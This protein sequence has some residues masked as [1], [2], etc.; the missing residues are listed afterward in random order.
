LG[1]EDLPVREARRIVGPDAMIG[2]STHTIEQARLAA[3]EG[4]DYIG[5]GPVFLSRTKQF[6]ELAGLALVEQIACEIGLPAFCIGGIE[7]ANVAQVAH[8][9][10]KRFVVG[11]AIS[12]AA[13]PREVARELLRNAGERT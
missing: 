6:V 7:P 13:D 4:A 9:G 2:L 11:A 3:V 5:V 1:Q 12:Q 8:A 10:G